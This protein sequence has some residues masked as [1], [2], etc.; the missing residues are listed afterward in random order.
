MIEK[1]KV[2]PFKILNQ[3]K[4]ILEKVNTIRSLGRVIEIQGNVIY[5]IGPNVSLGELCYIENPKSDTSIL[6]EVIGFKE[7]KIILS[8]LESITGIYP[9]SQVLSTGSPVEI[10]LSNKILG[11]IIDGLGRPLDDLGMLDNTEVRSLNNKPPNP[12]ERPIISEVLTTGIKS[13]DSFLTLGKGQRVGIFS[14][15]GI[16]KS[17]LLGMIARNSQADIN[18][19]A[20]IGERGREVQEFIENELGE[21]GL[22][23]SVVIV[24]SSNERPLQR[25]KAAYLATTIAEYF[26]DQN[27]D[28]ML[29]MDSVTRLAMAQREIG[30]VSGEPATTKGYPPSVFS[31][32]PELLERAGTSKNGSITGIYTVLVEGDDMND[33]I[34]DTIRGILDGHIVLSR[35]L[36]TKSHYPPVDIGQS[37][38]RNMKSII[39]KDHLSLVSQMRKYLSA[40][41]ENEEIINL[42]AYSKGSNPILD[43]SIL[44]KPE[45]D[46]FLCQDIYEYL[47]FHD[48]INQLNEIEKSI[49]Y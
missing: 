49:S 19:I 27:K 14:G 4:N 13:I 10:S 6:A 43:R 34:A 41:K 7:E 21:E 37:I 15:S 45:L 35:E 46:K 31:M 39:E 3:Y 9:N 20:L 44:L 40:Y 16:G 25:V 18:I 38:S 32:M 22:K 8:P 26:R 47:S 48:S 24:S 5:S 29:M 11:R 36:A 2:E 30:L 12:I 1:K 33:P 28:V 17:T 23:R 42:G